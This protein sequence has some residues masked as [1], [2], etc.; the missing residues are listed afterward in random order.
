MEADKS[1]SPAPASKTEAILA[2]TMLAYRAPTED[3]QLGTG[4][5]LKG[6]IAICLAG[7]SLLMGTPG[8]I[9]LRDELS[10]PQSEGGKVAAGCLV[11]LLA[12]VALAAAVITAGDYLSGRNA[13]CPRRR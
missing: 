2:P 10:R 3:P 9:A 13:R 1:A 7:F 5:V 6:A 8:V 12:L 4:G 11:I